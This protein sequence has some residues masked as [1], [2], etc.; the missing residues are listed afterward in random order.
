MERGVMQ[1]HSFRRAYESEGHPCPAKHTLEEV[2]KL[3]G[4]TIGTVH[5]VCTGKTHKDLHPSRP[6][7]WR[8]LAS[9]FE[10]EDT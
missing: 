3:V 4:V 7:Y 9:Y 1:I 8:L 10:F 2:A 6:L 5:S